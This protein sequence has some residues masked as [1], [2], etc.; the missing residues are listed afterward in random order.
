[1]NWR[2]IPC[3]SEALEELITVQYLKGQHIYSVT[4]LAFPSL[5]DPPAPLHRNLSAGSGGNTAT[6]FPR[7]SFHT[8]GQVLLAAAFP[9][10][11]ARTWGGGVWE[12]MILVRLLGMKHVQRA[13]SCTEAVQKYTVVQRLQ[14]ALARVGSLYFRLS[15]ACCDFREEKRSGCL[16][17]TFE[18][19]AL[20][21]YRPLWMSFHVSS[22]SYWRSCSLSIF[23]HLPPTRAGGAVLMCA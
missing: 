15:A 18:L 14:T 2:Q 19:L 5:P 7:H 20:H 13:G 11:L 12:E 22:D 1:M 9:D 10:G 6:A 17:N 4:S 3:S 23:L 8:E 21:S 16:C